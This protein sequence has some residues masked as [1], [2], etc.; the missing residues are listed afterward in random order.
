ME[1]ADNYFLAMNS[2]AEMFELGAS[3]CSR[4]NSI[5]TFPQQASK[6]YLRQ[7]LTHVADYSMAP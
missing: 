3:C 4:G 1:L 2:N 7:V 5:N 6:T